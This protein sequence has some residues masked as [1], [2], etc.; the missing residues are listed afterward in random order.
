MTDI[1]RNILAVLNGDSQH[2]SAA[3]V[4]VRLGESPREIQDALHEMDELDLVSMRNGL[5]RPYGKGRL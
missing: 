2:M 4:A 3:E 1:Q 5:Y